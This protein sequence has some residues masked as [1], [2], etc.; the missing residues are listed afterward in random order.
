MSE[1]RKRGGTIEIVIEIVYLLIT[2]RNSPALDSVID[3][4]RRY[5]T[6]ELGTD[7]ERT[8]KAKRRSMRRSQSIARPERAPKLGGPWCVL[9]AAC[10]AMA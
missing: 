3:S 5:C 7:R 10:N 8:T 2:P 1:Q 4:V 9:H 6:S